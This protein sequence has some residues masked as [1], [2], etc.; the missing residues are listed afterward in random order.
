TTEFVPDEI[1]ER[2]CVLGTAE[3]HVE[4]LKTLRDLGADQF[5]LYLMH[6]AMEQTLE[7]YGEEIIP[8]LT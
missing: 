8:K 5:N 4:K 1:V 7:V 6:D 2:F 3:E